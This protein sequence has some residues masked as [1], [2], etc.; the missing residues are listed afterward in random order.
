MKSFIDYLYQFDR[1]LVYPIYDVE[2][3]FGNACMN[4]V[5]IAVD[6]GFTSHMAGVTEKITPCPFHSLEEV[7]KFPW[8]ISLT[9]E[10]TL[11]ELENVRSWIAQS[12]V[13]MGGGSFGPLTITSDILGVEE[14]CRLVV[15]HPD[16]VYAVLERVTEFLILLAQKECSMGAEFI[17]IAEPVASLFA[18]KVCQKFCGN[19]LKKIFQAISVPGLLHVC[20][21]TDR[22][23]SCLLDTGAQV[24][25]IDYCTDLARCLALAPDNVVI[26]GNISPILLWEGSLKEVEEQM[27]LILDQT[28]DYKNFIF[29]SGC[30]VPDFAPRENV[31]LTVDMAKSAL[32]WSNDDYRLICSLAKIY[33]EKGPSAFEQAGRTG[34]ISTAV[35]TAAQNIALKRLNTK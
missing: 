12:R 17:W 18:P 24:I 6:L 14:C 3:D 9:G 13:P 1:R 22:Q 30:Q 32:L 5:S 29:G 23:F 26:M 2:K 8:N 10:R 11:S 27:R 7:E 4:N 33:C 31:Q 15:T 35:Q 25:S 20:G 28:R 19:Y 16:I 34:H 21:K